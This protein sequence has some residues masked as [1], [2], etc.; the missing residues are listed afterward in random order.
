[1]EWLF[2]DDDYVPVNDKDAFLDKSIL[3]IVNML[4]RIQ[5]SNTRNSKGWI[6]EINT[7][8]KFISTIIIVIMI[9][10]SRNFLFVAASGALILIELCFIKKEDAKKILSLNIIIILFTFVIL[11][12]SIIHGNVK[13]SILILFKVICTVNFVDIL[14]FTTSWHE[15]TKT[16]KLLFIPDIFIFVI[17]TTLRYIYLLGELSL[18]MLYAAR[19]RMIGKNNKKYETMSKIMGNLFLKSVEM[20]NELYYAMECRGFT[21][22]YTA[23]IDKKFA[24]KDFL[25]GVV[26]IVM[27]V[28]FVSF[29][30][31]GI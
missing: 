1:L 21:G 7:A 22:E 20:G 3:S 30:G 29:G 18:E 23:T 19:V 4:S 17:D 11:I 12:P 25:Y 9:S 10:L 31:F 2:K 8:L 15:V 13:N 27:A 5:R 6:Y 14:S 28:A 26:I 16:L 24:L